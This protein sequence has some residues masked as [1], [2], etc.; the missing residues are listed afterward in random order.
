[1]LGMLLVMC[2]VMIKFVFV[3]FVW[4]KFLINVLVMLFGILF[5]SC[6]I[7]LGLN[8]VENLVG[9]LLVV[10]LIIGSIVLSVYIL[11]S[12]FFN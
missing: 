10:V 8:V 5:C 6:R 12:V 4:V 3:N 7:F 11:G 9:L 2:V 1:M